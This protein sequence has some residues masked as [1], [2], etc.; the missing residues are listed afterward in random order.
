VVRCATTF[1]ALAALSFAGSA[2]AGPPQPVPPYVSKAPLPPVMLHARPADDAAAISRGLSRAVSAGRLSRSEASEYRAI[3]RRTRTVLGNVGGSRRT[4][5]ARVLGQV[6]WF[7]GAYNRPR[8]LAL[9]S[10]LDENARFLARRGL[11]A[12][13]TDVIGRGGILYRVGWGYGLQFHP[14]GNAIELNRRITFGRRQ[15][16]IDHA[17]ALAARLVPKSRGAEWEYYF[18]YAGAS[19]PWSSGM[20]QAVGAQALARAGRR[21]TAPDFFASA[22]RAYNS[23]PGRLVRRLSAGPWIRLYSFSGL[24]VLNAQLQAVLSIRNYGE[25]VH[26]REARAFA[27][28]LQGAARALFPQFDTGYWTRYSLGHESPLEYHR[29]HV[30]LA[31][32]LSESPGDFWAQ[33]HE[34]FARYLREP[35]QFKSG[36]RGPTLYPWPAEGF[37]D[38]ARLTFWVSKISRATVRV[39]GN[40]FSLSIPGK[41]WYSLVWSPGRRPPRTYRPVVSAVDLA[42]NRG[43]APL[44]PIQIA[45]DRAPP[46][47]TVR[48]EG[49]RLVWRARD[50]GTPWLRMTVVFRREGERRK[51]S[52]GRR[53]LAGSAR[54]ALPPSR[55][56]VVLFAMDSSGNRARVEVNSPPGGP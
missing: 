32:R 23:I 43:S 48:L 38:R 45:V 49:R 18:P 21:F 47:L 19:P 10:M 34:R 11:P 40:T 13:E 53:P 25:T 15:A 46:E 33:A 22:R 17:S 12:N 26:H 44:A 5:L 3:V 54:L 28:R 36:A 30:D 41:G 50:P 9:F 42:G 16:A 2:L 27:A 8:A 6:R 51:Q 24:V 37:R 1:A 7:A 14:L 20:A 55:W 39:G 4:V 29:Y 52:L 56:Q 31:K 35:P